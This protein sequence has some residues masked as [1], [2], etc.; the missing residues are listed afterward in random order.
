MTYIDNLP[1]GAPLS[2][3]GRIQRLDSVFPPAQADF[4]KFRLAGST[5]VSEQ[6]TS[7]E[8]I[9]GS[10]HTDWCIAVTKKERE[11]TTAKLDEINKALTGSG[12][13][14]ASTSSTASTA[15]TS[16]GKSLVFGK[17]LADLPFGA[18]LYKAEGIKA[19]DFIAKLK[20]NFPGKA[21]IIDRWATWCVP[22]LNEMPH[23][24]VLE[25]AS[26][27]LPVV[28]VY[29]CTI[30]NSSESKWKSKVVEL[31]Q[32]GIHFLIDET[33]DADLSSYFSFNGMAPGQ[34]PCPDRGPTKN[35][36]GQ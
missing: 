12:G 22:C 21:I 20:Q 1:G 16:L 26:T 6:K 14:T 36:R 31:Q 35:K 4:M 15:S 5:D 23:E 32:P 3:D 9:L 2:L 13:D 24:K 7:M 29:L 19:I 27:S 34:S 18:S 25:Q 8:H 30:I 28:F 11:R 10:M 17:P 33:L